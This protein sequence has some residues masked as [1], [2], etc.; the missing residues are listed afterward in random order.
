MVKVQPGSKAD[1]PGFDLKDLASQDDRPSAS[2]TERYGQERSDFSDL[3]S[4]QPEERV[5]RL[6][7]ES[8]TAAASATVAAMPAEALRPGTED[9]LHALHNAYLARLRDPVHADAQDRWQDLVRGGAA[10]QSDPLQQ[11]MQAA[12][13]SH[14]LDDLLGQTHS[15]ASVIDRLDALGS[16]DVLAPEPFDSVMHLFAP[17]QVPVPEQ[18]SLESLVQHSLPGLTRRE[19]HSMSLDSAMPF[20]GGTEPSTE[21]PRP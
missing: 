3:I 8:G 4:F 21:N 14:S 2:G 11:W 13:N 18:E 15:I 7:P 16:S 1:I 5:G 12:G 6:E 10:R 20:T 9:P 19:H 17:G